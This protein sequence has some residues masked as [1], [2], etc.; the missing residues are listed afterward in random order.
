MV[1][2]SGRRLLLQRASTIRLQKGY[3]RISNGLGRVSERRRYFAT[4]E[5][6]PEILLD[7]VTAIVTGDASKNN[8]YL[9]NYH[10]SN[11]KR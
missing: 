11:Q 5:I 4:P 9:K 8:N 7:L 3:K 2:G 1:W 6:G 10:G